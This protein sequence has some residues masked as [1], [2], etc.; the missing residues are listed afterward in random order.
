MNTYAIGSRIALIH[1]PLGY[2]NSALEKRVVGSVV[3]ETKTLVIV[4]VPSPFPA[5]KGQP[6]EVRLSK[7]KGRTAGTDTI[8]EHYRFAPE[9]APAVEPGEVMI[10]GYVFPVG[11]C[12]RCGRTDVLLRA[13]TEDLTLHDT[14]AGIACRPAA[15]ELPDMPADRPGKHGAR[16]GR[17]ICDGSRAKR[18]RSDFTYVRAWVKC[19][20]CLAQLEAEDRA[21][22]CPSCKGAKTC[23]A[24]V[25]GVESCPTCNGSGDCPT[26]EGSGIDPAFP[27][28]L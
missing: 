15:P 24:C 11:R 23:P 5:T 20:A 10:E 7:H 8:E 18:G 14:P 13:G 25:G 4:S 2:C 19:P 21:H 6:R 12:A 28:M 3:R 26:C 1:A 16:E 22:P 9:P 27:R 17:I